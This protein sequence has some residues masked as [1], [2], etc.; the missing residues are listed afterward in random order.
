MSTIGNNLEEEY[1]RMNGNLY[2]IYIYIYIFP[3]RL[4]NNRTDDADRVYNCIS[5]YLYCS[6]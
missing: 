3:E 4:L 2:D 5:T 1:F 6:M